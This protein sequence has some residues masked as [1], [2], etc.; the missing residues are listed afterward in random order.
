FLRGKRAT[1]NFAE[2][3]QLK[4]YCGEVVRER[5]V[6]DEGLITAGAVTSSIDLGLHLCRRWAGPEAVET[7]RKR[8]DYR[9]EPARTGSGGRE[10]LSPACS[11]TDRNWPGASGFRRSPP[12]GN[13]QRSAARPGRDSSDPSPGTPGDRT[14][15]APVESPRRERTARRDRAGRASRVD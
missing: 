10:G 11:T 3:D 15:R 5:I 7:I 13:P 8:M 9:G 14:A 12:F 2:Y 1:T 6:E 4:Q